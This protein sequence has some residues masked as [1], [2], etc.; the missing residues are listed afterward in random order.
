MSDAWQTDTPTE[1]ETKRFRFRWLFRVLLLLFVAALAWFW[2][3]PDKYQADMGDH[4]KY[5]SIGADNTERGIPRQLWEALPELF[6]E[7]LPAQSQSAR[8]VGGR[9]GYAQFGILS[10]ANRELPIG[11][12]Q[13]R[14]LGIDLVGLNCA[15]CHT[16][17]YRESPASD[18]T[19]VMGMPSNTVDLQG[20]FRFLFAC[21]A[22]ERFTV[23]RVMA[24]L[25]DRLSSYERLVY[26]R[27]VRAFRDN[28]RAQQAK[29]V[30]WTKMPDF[31]PGRVDTFT[32]YKRLYFD[33]PP[34]EHV[35]TADFPSLWRQRPR[36]GMNLHWDGNNSSVEERNLSAALGAGF[37][38]ATLDFR[39]KDRIAE[40]IMD[41]GPPAYPQPID[42]KLAADGRAVYGRHCARCHG[43][44][45]I[46]GFPNEQVGLVTPIDDIG[47]DPNRLD[48]FD[49]DFVKY[50]NTLGAGY[51]W[52]FTHFKKTAGYANSPLDGI[53]LRA[54]YL[55]NGSVPTLWHLLNPSERPA[56]F[57]RGNDVY[58]FRNLGFAWETPSAGVR[59]FFD[60]DTS[61]RG[62]GNQGHTYGADLPPAEK[63]AVI[64]FLKTL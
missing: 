40:W 45:A 60:F 58:D 59:R 64:E 50:V 11:F 19:L 22:D 23:E 62:N 57:Y 43:C 17:R 2:W 10:E 24:H 32:P 56:R 4:F 47:T 7:H 53:W 48:S 46:D 18:A 35:G 15:I 55:H 39:S 31:G 44:E 36:V 37:I 33:L 27:A 21:A 1:I 20:Y 38:P 8:Y 26:P 9:E 63:W 30:Y 13:R 16:G 29:F 49:A 42:R 3:T 54:P 28:V 6:P 5:A 61:G 51:E 25:H 34:G 12:S 52:R 14:V 41:F